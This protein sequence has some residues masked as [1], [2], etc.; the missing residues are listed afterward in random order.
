MG[1]G[2]PPSHWGWGLGRGLCPSPEN[3]LD[4]FLYQNG[5]FCAFWVA[6]FI[7]YL[8]LFYMQNGTFGLPKLK[9]T[10]AFA[11]AKIERYRERKGKT[12]IKVLV[13]YVDL[14][15]GEVETPQKALRAWD[16]WG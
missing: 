10:A 16:I 13:K 12:E 5:D 7:V 8:K 9:V 6:L 3:F 14:L 2:Y 4:F 1:R 15:Y 11:L